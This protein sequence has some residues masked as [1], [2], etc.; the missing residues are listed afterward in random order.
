MKKALT[1]AGFLLFS[2]MLPCRAMASNFSQ[3]YVFGDSLSDTGNIFTATEGLEN[4]E[5]AFPPSPPYAQ[6]R[7]SN[8]DIWVDFVGDEIRLTPTTLIPPQTNIPTDGV[9]FATGGSSSGLN[10]AFVP[11]LPLP[12]VLGQVGLFTQTLQANNQQADPNALYTVWGGANDYLFGGVTDP[13]Q[14]VNNLS[15]AI[16]SLTQAGAKNIAVFNLP[17]LGQ[18]PLA[19]AN[20]ISPELT[21]LTIAHNAALEQALDG[22]SANPE[23]NIIPVDINSLFNR[24]VAN[25]GEFGFTQ[26]SAIP[27]VVGDFSN[28]S[29]V[30]DNPDEFIFFDAVHPSSKSHRLVA[31]A[32]LSAI[33]HETVPEP[34]TV[35]STLVIGA[36]GT[37]GVLK[38]KRKNLSTLNK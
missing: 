25:P 3:F 15:N 20:G 32:T 21:Q 11:D 29:S 13:N 5:S 30:C 31:D 10:N 18:T 14:T 8:G 9:N 12:G 37:V 4:P 1:T 6:G 35:L 27:C 33:K 28:I 2:L 7:F 24:A 16:G 23:V 19:I 36:V 34:S 38:R 17:D 26:N 22:F